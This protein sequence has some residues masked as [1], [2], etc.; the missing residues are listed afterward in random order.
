MRRI[1]E[2]TVEKLEYF[3][4]YIEAYLVATKR[5]PRK[6]YIDAFAGTGKCILCEQK[7]SSKGGCRCIKCGKGKVVDGSALISLKI[8]KDFTGYIFIEIENKNIKN[9]EKFINEE[10]DLEKRKKILI[11][12]TDS[13]LLLRNIYKYISQYTGC[14]ILLDPEGPELDW[15]TIKYLSKIKKAELLILYPYDMALVR[16][17]R[18]YSNKLDKFYGTNKWSEIYNDKNILRPSEK[19]NKLLEFYINN[20]KNLGFDY[21]EYKQIRKRLRGG[22]ALYHFILA[23]HHPAGKKIMSHIFNKEL[24]GQQ[25]FRL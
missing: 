22:K 3:R 15:E 5:L 20:L 16:L 12:Q 9:L 19:K 4:K 13:N 11:K 2:H 10:V 7:C 21:V 1:K 23:T 6:F 25:K 14:L 8:K 24:D 17:T 18:D